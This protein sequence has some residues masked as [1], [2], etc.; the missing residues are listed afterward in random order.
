MQALRISIYLFALIF[1][2]FIVVW[3][4][5][6]GLIF[7][8]LFLIP[9]D[10]VIRCIFH[11]KWK[12]KEL[13]IKLG[14]LTITASII[15]YMINSDALNIAAGSALGFMSAQV[16]AGLFYQWAI[17]KAFWIKVNGSDFFGILTDSV[18]FQIVAFSAIDP[19]IT[20]SQTALK[21]IGGV[22]WYWLIFVKLKLH[23]KWK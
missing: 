23:K 1:A 2:N 6:T 9:F 13:I 7:T 17:K 5:K 14:T 16:I 11:E 22:F 12:G 19:T 10:F 21:L 8:A 4:G 20:A 3:Y 15:T 18:V